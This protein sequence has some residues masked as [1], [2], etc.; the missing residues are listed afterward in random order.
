MVESISKNRSVE[1]LTE[2]RERIESQLA[3]NKSEA[4]DLQSSLLNRIVMIKK[5]D[6]TAL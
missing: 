1:Q 4:E 5:E 6:L 2:D 3:E